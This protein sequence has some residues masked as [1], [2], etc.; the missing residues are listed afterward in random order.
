MFVKKVI[1]VYSCQRFIHFGFAFVLVLI[2]LKKRSPSQLSCFGSHSPQMADISAGCLTG[3]GEGTA[4]P[5]IIGLLTKAVC[6]QGFPLLLRFC[7]G[8]EDDL[9]EI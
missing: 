8:R 6:V 5:L 9:G 4:D 7:Q 3:R 2:M 1:F